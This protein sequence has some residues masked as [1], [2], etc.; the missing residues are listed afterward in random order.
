MR[1]GVR[2]SSGVD[3]RPPD[4]AR[5]GG[6]SFSWRGWLVVWLVPLLI[7]GGL[8][9]ALIAS[10]PLPA[11]G[12]GVGDP[13]YPDAGA[14]GWDAQAYTVRLALDADLA[15]LSATTTITGIAT[16]D[17]ATVGF[18]LAY[19]VTRATLN[20]TDVRVVGQGGVN[21]VAVPPSPLRS[22]QAFTL[23]VSYA[24]D[25]SE[26]LEGDMGD[27]VVR[28]QGELLIAGEPEASAAW[29]AANDHPSDAAFFEL[30]ATVPAEM[31][32]ISVGRLVSRDADADP[33]TATWH[34]ATDEELAPYLTFVTAGQFD[35][36]EA[37]SDG[38]P[39]VYAVSHLLDSTMRRAAL[40]ALRGTPATIRELELRYGPYPFSQIGGVVSGVDPVW[41]GLETQ[42]RPVYGASLASDGD[43]P[44]YLLAHELA[45][46]W[47]GDHVRVATWADIVNNEGWATFA[48]NEV[49]A[50]RVGA[51]MDDELRDVWGMEPDFWAA[52]IDDPGVDNMFGTTYE[53]GGAALQALRVLIGDEEFF[54]LARA[55]VQEPGARSFADFRAFVED[56][57]DRDLTAF[58]RAWYTADAAPA[59]DPSLGWPG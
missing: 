35:I 16:Q 7:V 18:D 2:A 41:A 52:P 3:P 46:M 17:L 45:H 9:A 14:P 49:L 1:R 56:R 29:F 40:S 5:S 33:D 31:E 42:T 39:G 22:G 26:R 37:T 25:P 34:W 47:F 20:G 6:S 15:Q 58:W 19:P 53:R 54:A 57:T 44:E 13:Y 24:G 8:V 48:A 12:V 23:E 32:A 21:R 55:W 36:E 43:W 11:L 28:A 30:Y 10:R 27:P 38:R 59:R 4:V 51:S 50:R